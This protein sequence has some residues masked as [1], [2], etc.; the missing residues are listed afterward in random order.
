MEVKPGINEEG[1]GGEERFLADSMLGKLARW[2]RTLGY[3]VEYDNDIDDSSLIQ[4]AITEGRVILTRDTLLTKRRRVRGR[5]L[6]IE[7]GSIGDQLR[8]VTGMFKIRPDR[9]LSRCLRC[10]AIL[11]EA[12]KTM[13]KEKVPPYVYTT[14]ERFVVCPGCSRIY[15]AGTHK[16]KMLKDLSRLIERDIEGD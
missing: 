13:V 14:Q 8:Q 6:F 4:R 3:D 1:E 11:E 16:G 2:M 10:N 15:W 7:S 5:Y 12:D 9:I